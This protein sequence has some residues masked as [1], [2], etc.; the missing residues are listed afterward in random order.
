LEIIG[1]ISSGIKNIIASVVERFLPLIKKSIR[2]EIMIR[3]IE[4]VGTVRKKRLKSISFNPPTSEF[5]PSI[6]SQPVSLSLNFWENGDEEEMKNH[7]RYPQR[8][9][10]SGRSII[11][12]LDVSFLS[13]RKGI[14]GKIKRV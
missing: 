12:F 2:D 13:T 11:N 3:N 14:R 1:K 9:K 5:Q 10:K 7:G 8:R 6:F 4:R